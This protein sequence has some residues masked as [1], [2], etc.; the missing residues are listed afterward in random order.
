[1]H[2]F[3][4]ALAASIAVG[5]LVTVA[6]CKTSAAPV[7]SAIGTLPPTAVRV[8]T[9]AATTAVAAPPAATP[10]PAG[11]STAVSAAPTHPGTSTPA[12]FPGIW[13]ITTWQQYRAAQAS[14]EQGHQPWLLDPASVVQAWAGSWWTTPSPVHRITPDEFQVTKPGTNVVYTVRGTRPDPSGPAPIWVITAI[15]HS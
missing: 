10:T 3:S 5:V 15:A 7:E 1:M 8:A 12:P 14:V 4:G 2:R 6:G 13:D 9:T 11:G